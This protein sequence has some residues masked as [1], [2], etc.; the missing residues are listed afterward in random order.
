MA[1]YK[2]FKEKKAD[3]FIWPGLNPATL[4]NAKIL[5]S[6]RKDIFSKLV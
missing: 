2:R 4:V 3:G 5:S 1:F 6:Q